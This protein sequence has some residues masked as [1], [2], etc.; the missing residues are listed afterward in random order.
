[1]SPSP[2]RPE[3]L[4]PRL[5]SLLAYPATKAMLA[6]MAA[7]ALFRLLA[8]APNILGL[9][10]ELAF[11]VMG[12]K[13]AVEALVNTAHGR[14]EA[15]HGEDLMATDGDGVEQIVLGVLATVA[16]LAVA[17][18]VGPLPA[19]ALLAVIVLFMPA[20]VMLLSINHSLLNALNPLAWFELIGR[21]GLPYFGV[22]AVFTVLAIASEFAA[23]ALQS[24]LGGIGLV[25]AGFVSLFVLVA[26]Y[27]VLGDLLHR[28]A[29][30]L[31]LDI[32]PAVARATY[33][34][35]VEDEAMA[36]AADLAARGEP[37]AAAERLA[38]LFRGRG[39]SDPV[40]EQYRRYLVAAGDLAALAAHDRE[41]VSSLLVTGKDKAALAVAADTMARVPDFRLALP[42]QI[43]R[44][45]ALAARQGQSQLAVALARDFESRFPASPELPGVVLVAARLQSE[46]LGQDAAARDRLRALLASH[47]GHPQAGEARDLLAA[48]DRILGPAGA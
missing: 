8:H 37:A 42:E 48:L 5:P 27:H 33:A 7:L 26:S 32:T 3:P 47:P 38:G 4:L 15:L 9:L 10:F 35:P 16:L 30:A 43:A 20:A 28:H 13:L 14:Y 17:R 36:L 39:A 41:Y 19:L 1:M 6:F 34:N 46:R 24:A 18:W 21:I 23:W 45:V 31:G 29:D 11:W 44:L 12:Y 40:H 25:P 2:R 22:V